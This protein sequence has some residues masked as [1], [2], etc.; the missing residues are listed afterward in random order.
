MSKDI[1]GQ[2]DM[3][4]GQYFTIVIKQSDYQP[5]YYELADAT[6]YILGSEHFGNRGW[7]WQDWMLDDGY[8]FVDD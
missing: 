6:G 7:H 1:G 3:Y 5:V 2:M 8:S 4:A